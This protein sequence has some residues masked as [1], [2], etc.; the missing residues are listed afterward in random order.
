LAHPLPRAA[1]LVAA[2]GAAESNNL[3]SAG[4]IRE[5]LADY[6]AAGY[7]A[8]IIEGDQVTFLYTGRRGGPDTRVVLS[9]ER[10]G[11]PRDTPR[12]L[13]VGASAL[14]YHV[15]QLDPTARFLYR[16]IANGRPMA[17][18]LNPLQALKERWAPKSEVRMPR[19]GRDPARDPR[20][21]PAGQVSAH[22][23]PST[24][25]R[26]PR[27]L[28]VYTPAGY[29]AAGVT[30]PFAFFHDGGA[31]LDYAGAATI[32][33][34]LI[35]DGAIPPLLAVFANAV[36]RGWE[37]G[38]NDAHVRFCAEEVPAFVAARYPGVSADPTRRAVIGASLGGLISDY[39]AWTRPDVYGLVGAYSGYTA[40][41]DYRMERLVAGAPARPVRFYLVAG[42]YE[43]CLNHPHAPEGG[44]NDLLDNQRRFAAT[45]AQEGYD[46]VAREYYDGHNWGFWADHLPEAL[47]WM[48]GA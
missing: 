6:R 42:Q 47:R 48:F 27:D 44:P 46:C 41:D 24:A 25:L 5:F 33:D 9:S 37:Y 22:T 19:Y 4:L 21:G 31:Y 45:L 15:E 13:R 10:D 11:W 17:D 23:V 30:Y 36:R 18:P 28:W 2:V 35:A 20:P 38:L 29:P 12:L 40:Y 32:L 26:G 8:P 3:P 7:S 1:D 14:Y 16:F 39:V 43:R 34:N